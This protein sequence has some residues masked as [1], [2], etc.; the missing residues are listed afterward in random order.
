[1]DMTVKHYLQKFG[2]SEATQTFLGK[3]QKMFI[4]GQWVEASDGQTCDVIEPST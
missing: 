1:M 3:H 4:A 2:V